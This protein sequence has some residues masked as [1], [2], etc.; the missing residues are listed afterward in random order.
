[1]WHFPAGCGSM[2]GVPKNKGRTDLSSRKPR[3]LRKRK[4]SK[5][6][7]DTNQTAARVLRDFLKRHP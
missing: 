2:E 1:M 5:A 4:K 7:E 3:R 6:K